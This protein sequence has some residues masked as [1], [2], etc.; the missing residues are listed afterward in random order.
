MLQLVKI[1][2]NYVMGGYKQVALEDVSINF[3]KNEFVA[4]TGVS[5]SGKTTLLN[6]IGG[7]DSYDAG[8]LLI[9]GKSTKSFLDRDWDRYRNHSVGFIFQNYQLIPNLTVLENVELGMALSGA[10]SGEKK[11]RAL[12][13][14]EKVGLKEHVKKKPTQLSGGQMQRVAIARALAND[15]E[16]ILADEPTGALDTKTSVQIMD[17]I[18]KIAKE[19]LVIMVTHNQKLAE[20]YANR[21]IHFQDGKL[22]SDS[23]PFLE[24]D[25]YKES[26]YSLKKT[27]MNFLTA[28]KLSARNMATK[29]FRLTL[30]VLASSIG[31]IGVA[32]V[33]S[34]SNGFNEFS[35]KEQKKYMENYPVK[36]HYK[37]VDKDATEKLNNKK[38]PSYFSMEKEVIPKK[39][40][41]RED[42]SITFDSN[43]VN[44]MDKNLYLFIGS[45]YQT[46]MN[47]IRKTAQGVG[48]VFDTSGLGNQSFQ[49]YFLNKEGKSLLEK[50]YS[51]LAGKYPS[52]ADDLILIVSQANELD[53]SILESLGF[54]TDKNISFHDLLSTNIK[55]VPNDL[56]Y[57]A[58]GSGKFA[59]KK[60]DEA[61]FSKPGL[62]KLRISCILRLKRGRTSKF[63]DGLVANNE[64]TKVV[65]E[66]NK[67]S[68]IVKAQKSSKEDVIN[69]QAV[70]SEKVNSLVG[71][72]GFEEICIIPK[73]GNSRNKIISYLE[74]WNKGKKSKDQVKID[75]NAD[76]YKEDM[77]KVLNG[78]TMILVAIASISLVVSTIM[79]G[80]ITYVSVLER[81]RE[82]GILR[83]LGARKKDITRVFNAET[84]II[85]AS[86]GIFGV[87]IAYLFS[88]PINAIAIRLSEIDDLRI[89]HLK[90]LHAIFLIALSIS[91]TFLGGFI[92]A[93]LA[94]RKNPVEALRSE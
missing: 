33:L 25:N 94:A 19:K 75:D 13:V 83:A 38:I 17:L 15:P 72:E 32:I 79:I 50:D 65:H 89:A 41:E 74:A 56:Y 88:F 46:G 63:E 20:E 42:G 82:I 35:Q 61:M 86:A 84:F 40:Q 80:I 62:R 57:Q 58:T 64:L 28:L 93:K 67:N 49:K 9:N 53:T 16:I 23:N 39:N 87:L 68:A 22:I 71:I 52:S 66:M 8:D 37:T 45:S 29:K 81:I 48:V 54:G 2:K 92:P 6:I 51:L 11:K 44:K 36:I 76:E 78:V 43:Y 27:T 26:G 70:Q 55:L 30:T 5:G 12:Q 77:I 60:V 31:I 59:L 91:L 18:R 24:E 14:L 85:G 73:N 7:L 21:V 47:L 1:H 69:G 3:R 4:V 10:N 90:P 34:L